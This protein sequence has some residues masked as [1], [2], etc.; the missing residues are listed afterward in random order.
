MSK[1][2]ED[3]AM[4]Q[5]TMTLY[6]AGDRLIVGASH[7]VRIMARRRTSPVICRALNTVMSAELGESA[8]GADSESSS[9]GQ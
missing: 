8:P 9:V 7:A 2:D 6:Q 4:I 1:R 3:E 5:E